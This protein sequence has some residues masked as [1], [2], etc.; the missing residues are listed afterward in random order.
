[1]T[2]REFYEG[3]TTV[4]LKRLPAFKD[5]VTYALD[6]PV[7]QYSG[8]VMQTCT[9]DQVLQFTNDPRAETK[10]SILSSAT[11]K[12]VDNPVFL[13]YYEDASRKQV[14]VREHMCMVLMVEGRVL[15]VALTMSPSVPTSAMY[16][17]F[18]PRDMASHVVRVLVIA[19]LPHPA[20]W[21]ECLDGTEDVALYD[22]RGV[23]ASWFPYHEPGPEGQSSV[24]LFTRR[25][26]LASMLRDELGTELLP[27]W[28]S[29]RDHLVGQA[30]RSWLLARTLTRAC[31]V[32][33]LPDLYVSYRASRKCVRDMHVHIAPFDVFMARFER[34][35]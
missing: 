28:N 2:F 34:Q 9:D 1:M 6:L 14:P 33:R 7:E 10:L 12:A 11:A 21:W 16:D 22:A 30:V 23:F 24:F 3:W 19:A 27:R 29:A 25:S 20:S 13:T 17:F 18:L 15:G 4:G 8:L 35:V 32:S 26:H 31:A 5:Y